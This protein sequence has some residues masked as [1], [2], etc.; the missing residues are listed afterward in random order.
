MPSTSNNTVKSARGVTESLQRTRVVIERTLHG[1]ENAVNHL[2]RDG[3]LIKDT[4]QEHSYHLKGAL[5]S[6]KKRLSSLKN[7]EIWEKYSLLGSLVF[8]FAVV[9]YIVAKRLRLLSLLMLS[10]GNMFSARP[11]N[12]QE[13]IVSPS[14]RYEILKPT[15]ELSSDNFCS[16]NTASDSNCVDIIESEYVLDAPENSL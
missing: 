4:L 5:G 12:L 15:E 2:T 16:L 7:A 1:S 14:P 6:S 13:K 11:N 9:L 8:F 10:F 3:D